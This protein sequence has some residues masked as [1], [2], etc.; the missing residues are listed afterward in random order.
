MFAAPQ[1]PSP[2]SSLSDCPVCGHDLV[3]LEGEADRYCVNLECPAQRVQRI[4]H[5]A[6]RGR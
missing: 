6:S 3:R 2:G 5:F 4:F 1:A